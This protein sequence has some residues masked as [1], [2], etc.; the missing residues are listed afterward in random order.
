M[1]YCISTTKYYYV[2]HFK[3]LAVSIIVRRK[4]FH[5]T[6][7]KW[8]LKSLVAEMIYV[9]CFPIWSLNQILLKHFPKS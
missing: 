7:E 6:T 8:R 9:E 2:S 3:A 1:T 5:L 4:K